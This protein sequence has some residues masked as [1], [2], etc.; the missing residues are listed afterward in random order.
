MLKT[1][2][3]FFRIMYILHPYTN[4]NRK[5]HGIDSIQERLH[6]NKYSANIINKI[7]IAADSAQNR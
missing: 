7:R 2:N 3:F 1:R 5:L 6:S 4:N